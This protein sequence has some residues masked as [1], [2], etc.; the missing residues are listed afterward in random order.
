VEEQ[1]SE[2]GFG[3]A[4]GCSFPA[5]K[6]PGLRLSPANAGLSFAT[7][8]DFDA[9]EFDAVQADIGMSVTASQ[10]ENSFYIP[11][12]TCP[13]CGE[14]MRLARTEPL[15]PNSHHQMM[16]DCACGFEYRMAE[17]ARAGA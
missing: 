12:V 5:P 16:F 1:R 11:R 7:A 13:Q 10:S 14:H 9:I 6:Y 4:D 15:V 17:R 3:A 2:C 8:A